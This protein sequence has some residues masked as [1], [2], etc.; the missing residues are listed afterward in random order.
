MWLI[1]AWSHSSS[2]EHAK[3]LVRQGCRE[4]RRREARWHARPG[5]TALSKCISLGPVENF[6]QQSP[7]GF[8]AQ[9]G[10]MRL[11]ARDD[12]AVKLVLP[13]IVEAEVEAV[14][15]PLAAL[16]AGNSGSE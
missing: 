12:H 8:I 6:G 16:G 2:F 4:S 1:R 13:E 7:V 9:V 5:T 15:M 10:L 11:R 3:L 14:Q